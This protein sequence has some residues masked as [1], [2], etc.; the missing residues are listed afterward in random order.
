MLPDALDELPPCEVAAV[1]GEGCCFLVFVGLFLVFMGLIEKHGTNPESACRPADNQRGFASFT[2]SEILGLEHITVH[3]FGG[4]DIT[5][6]PSDGGGGSGITV[7]WTASAAT[8]T[9]VEQISVSAVLEGVQFVPVSTPTSFL[10]CPA[11]VLLIAC[12]VESQH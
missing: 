11:A 2:E 3:T 7:E 1:H 6:L 4:G 12:Q 9:A 10:L 5:V 8:Q